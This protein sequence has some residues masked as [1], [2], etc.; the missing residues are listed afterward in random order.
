MSRGAGSGPQEVGLERETREERSE[1]VHPGW[2]PG[3]VSRR[4]RIREF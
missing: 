4:D 2:D 1:E 3:S